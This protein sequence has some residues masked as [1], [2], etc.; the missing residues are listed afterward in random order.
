MPSEVDTDNFCRKCFHG[1]TNVDYAVLEC[2]HKFHF[3]CLI[4]HYQDNNSCPA[5]MKTLLKSQIV[6]DPRLLEI[7][8][9]EQ[10]RQERFDFIDL[11]NWVNNNLLGG[12][13]SVKFMIRSVIFSVI[14]ITMMHFIS[15]YNMHQEIDIAIKQ[16][17]IRAFRRLISKRTSDSIKEDLLCRVTKLGQ[18]ENVK[19]LI[20]SGV[21]VYANDECAMK[22]AYQ[23]IFVDI[24]NE[25]RHQ[26]N[27]KKK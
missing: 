15:Q 5:C 18:I 24:V 2:K 6:Y 19:V 12:L 25:L 23:G 13:I 20:E 27:S 17:D 4:K 1:F 16:N 11:L 9:L 26:Y 21:N 8:R 3:R 14:V 22:N 7:N 10:Q